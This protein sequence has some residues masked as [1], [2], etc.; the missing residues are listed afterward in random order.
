MARFQRASLIDIEELEALADAAERGNEVAA[1]RL[2]DLNRTYSHRASQRMRELENKKLDTKALQYAQYYLDER[3]RKYFGAGRG[4]D[5][6][7]IVENLEQARKFL[8]WQTST[9]G[10]ER[11]R[12]DKI[13]DS[14]QKHGHIDEFESESDRRTFLKFLESDAFAD[15]KK[16][17]GSSIITEAQNAIE[18]GRSM[19]ELQQVYSEYKA[20]NMDAI[21]Y[22]EKWS[23][24]KT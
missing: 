4:A 22:W 5:L 13:L 10:G 21:K 17:V 14:L 15:F 23:K 20:A 9:V 6:D 12:V 16:V 19:E 18:H 7:E 3:G 2:R 8:S 1:D 24:I 11:A